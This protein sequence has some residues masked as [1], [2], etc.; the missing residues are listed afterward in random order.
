MTDRIPADALLRGLDEH[1]IGLAL[2]APISTRL[3][4]LV[5]LVEGAGDRTNRK[6]LLGALILAAAADGATLAA[7]VH[8][9]R[10]ATVRDTLVGRG[11]PSKHVRFPP[12]RPGPK[13]RKA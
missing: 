8:R 9:Y 5:G 11:N 2:S 7:L 3:D 12:R 13:P 4:D 6:E 10:T 1:S